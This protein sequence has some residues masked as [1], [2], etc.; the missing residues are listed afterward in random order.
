MAHLIR[1]NPR[2]KGVNLYEVKQTIMQ[3][4]DD[5]MLFLMYNEDSINAAISMLMHIEANTGL[6]ISYKKTCIYRIGSLRDT[7]VKCYTIRPLQWSDGDIPMLGVT[8]TNSKKG[9]TCNQY[10]E[11][12]SKVELVVNN[13]CNRQLTLIGK[14][15]LV[16]SLMGSLF[17]Y[18]MAILPEML[19]AQIK[20]FEGIITKF[21]WKNKCPK[22]SLRVL[23]NDKI[24]G[25]LG[26]VNIKT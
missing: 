9:Q 12:L 8:I 7:N 16:N 5:T 22:I 25:G 17:T 2:I 26:L 1:N 10:N 11:I 18:C 4:A 19:T 3:F 13:W 20:H 23:M 21:L 15:L 24:E 14:V 6:R